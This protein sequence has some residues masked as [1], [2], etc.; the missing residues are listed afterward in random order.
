MDDNKGKELDGV[1]PE[2][3]ET[4]NE[5][6]TD[7]NETPEDIKNE[8][9]ELAKTFREELEKA[10]AEAKAV[11]ENPPEEPQILIQD[12][13][14]ISKPSENLREKNIPEEELCECCGEKRRG[15]KKNPDSPYCADCERGLRH[16]PFEFL[17][18]LIALIVLGFSFYACF[19]FADYSE[20]Y[21]ASEK[22][23]EY[24]EKS[25]LYTAYDAYLTA[26]DV[27]DDNS[28][29]GEMVYKR[30]LLNVL[31]LGGVDEIADYSSQFKAWELNLPHLKAVGDAF[32][33]A[34]EFNAAADEGYNI[35]YNYFGEGEDFSQVDFDGLIAELDALES[36]AVEPAAVT[37]EESES[38]TTTAP[39][40]I[41]AA[42]YERSM[43]LY[44][45]FY[46]A[47][48]CEKDYSVRIGF[49]EQIKNEYPDLVWLYNPMLGD[50]YAK[51]GAD[52]TEYCDYIRGINSE[53]SSADVV[54]ATAL[55]IKGDL[56][57]CIEICNEKISESDDYSYEFYRQIA[58]CNLINGNYTAAYENAMSSYEQYGGSVQICDTL[59]LCAAAV[60]NEETYA[61]M[62][63]LFEN[64]GYTLSDE[65]IQFK[66]GTLSLEKI[67]TEGDYDVE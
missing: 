58:L 24:S 19:V 55:R 18:I 4:K 13:E 39:Y 47:T 7:P 50:L 59:A 5:P 29:N 33:F 37:D 20:I 62:E 53:D 9:E 35:L 2:S 45:K 16:Y 67:L 66:E 42:K 11:A 14:D 22:A 48:V 41:T 8:M 40:G 56:D 10:K 15:T 27:M 1:S 28:V 38:V 25:K 32:R 31:K 17:N 51:S 23:D 43:L 34:E 30:S 61:E 52:V 60:G 12:L 64:S 36:K 46:A 44:L 57:G 26:E 63:S 54:Q 49:L 21:V 65:V 3:E 6:Q